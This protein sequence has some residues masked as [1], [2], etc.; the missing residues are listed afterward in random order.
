VRPPL[1]LVGA[2]RS[3]TTALAHA[4]SAQSHAQ[5]KGVF[6]VNG[7]L[8]YFVLRWLDADDLA[9]RHFRA[10][11]ISHALR[12]RPAQGAAASEWLA[13][14]DGALRALAGRVSRG[15]YPASRVG[16]LS[17]RRDLAAAVAGPQG[18]GDKYN[19][20]LMQLPELHAT[21]P[22]AR[23]IFLRRDP[24][25]VIVSMLAWT[26]DRPWNP[27]TAQD[28]EAKWVHWN[29]RWLAFRSRLRPGQVLEID[30]ADMCSGA[31]HRPVEEFTQ[32][33]LSEPLSGYR[34]RSGDRASVSPEAE[35]VWMALRDYP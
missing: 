28:A 10:D 15:A 17:A 31:A 14:A 13:A 16:V 25:E 12:R 26:G 20:Y 34:R 30:Y 19:E 22:D 6:T 21:F 3:G 9:A 32:L 29:S 35:R 18:W 2:Q 23:W 24:A 11:E 33:D 7:K 8:W 1:F 27:A 4:I 5:R